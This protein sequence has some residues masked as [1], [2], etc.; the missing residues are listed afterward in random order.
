MLSSS[1]TLYG[2]TEKHIEILEK[3]DRE[4]LTRLFAVPFSCS[5]EAV[6]LETGCIPIKFIIK[7]RRL[8][9]Y[10]S[11]LN[12][13][14]EEL[15]K[16]FFEVQQKFSSKNDWSEQIKI[17]MNDLDINLTEHQIKS[18]KKISFKKIIKEKLKIKASE[19]LFSYKENENRSKLY[20]LKL[21]SKFEL[22]KYLK[23]EKLSTKEK[24]L[25]FSLRTRMTNVKT[26]YRNISISSTCIVYFAMTRIL[27][28]QKF[29]C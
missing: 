8:M 6:Y 15:V 2:I 10:W 12:K 3:C 25:L 27:R 21:K 5:Y 16:R 19:Y 20:K 29:I 14:D 26:N 22:Q 11:L 23:S 1:E 9:F 13:P 7:G 18:M 28:N 4:L 24:R 17:D